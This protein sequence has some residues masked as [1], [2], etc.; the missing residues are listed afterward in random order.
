MMSGEVVCKESQFRHVLCHIAGTD[1]VVSSV[2]VAMSDRNGVRGDEMQG[3]VEIQRHG[4]A[5]GY[6]N[7]YSAIGTVLPGNGVKL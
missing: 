1:R 4:R 3:A 5:D 7:A 2:V 6:R